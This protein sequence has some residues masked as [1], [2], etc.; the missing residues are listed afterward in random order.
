MAETAQAATLVAPKEFEFREYEIPE[1]G[2]EDGLLKVEAVGICGSDV[3]QWR[4]SHSWAVNYPCIL[5]HE[6]AG[7]IAG[8][9][10]GVALAFAREGA[11]VMG[12][13]RVEEAGRET[14]RLAEATPSK[15]GNFSFVKMDLVQ[16]SE[17]VAA[18]ANVVKTYGRLDLAQ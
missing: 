13:G 10:R 1:I 2:P 16:E 7:T 4:G 18:V 5:G 9:G 12:A 11:K 8:I 14:Q 3:H 15:P 6:F 17:I